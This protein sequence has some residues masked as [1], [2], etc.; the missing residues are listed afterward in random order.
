[1]AIAYYLVAE[2]E[3]VEHAANLGMI[4][5]GIAHDI[6]KEQ[7][8]RLRQLKKDIISVCFEI[9]ISE[10]LGNTSLFA[11]MEKKDFD[12]I[13]KFLRSRTVPRGAAIVKQ[14]Q[15]GDSMFLIARGIA[16]VLIEDEGQTS[17]VATLF[18]GDILG[19]A[20]LL[21]STPRNATAEAVTPR[22]LYELKRVDLDRICD[23][24]PPI[25]DQVREIDR[26]R[27]KENKFSTDAD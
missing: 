25:H 17:Q 27:L 23:E 9:E 12:F 19:E 16:N 18:A 24:H 10:L 26:E 13:Q 5:E 11:D 6:L 14:G 15:Q 1:M 20:A 4:Q 8:E 2:Q 22:S 21:H 3:S 7:S